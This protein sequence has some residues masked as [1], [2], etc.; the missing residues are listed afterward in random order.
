MYKKLEITKLDIEVKMGENKLN[1]PKLYTTI[2]RDKIEMVIHE[3]SIVDNNIYLL[4]HIPEDIGTKENSSYD[5]I[6]IYANELFSED[7]IITGRN[8]IL[9]SNDK[10]LIYGNDAIRFSYTTNNLVN[11]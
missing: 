8:Y 1:I 4:C 5:E 10:E 11:L 3:I 7:V 2:I 6:K 9:K